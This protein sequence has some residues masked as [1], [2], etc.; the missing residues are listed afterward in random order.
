MAATKCGRTGGVSSGGRRATASI[1]R[2]PRERRGRGGGEKGIHTPGT[3]PDERLHRSRLRGGDGPDAGAGQT[4]GHAATIP[5]PSAAAFGE[6]TV[7]GDP[8]SRMSIFAAR[9]SELAPIAGDRIDDRS[10][11]APCPESRLSRAPVR[12]APPAEGHPR[13]LR[14]QVDLAAARD[15]T[16]RRPF[17][18]NL[19]VSRAPDRNG[20]GRPAR[21]HAKRPRDRQQG[22]PL[23]ACGAFGARRER[24]RCRRRHILDRPAPRG[25]PCEAQLRDAEQAQVMAGI[26][27]ARSGGAGRSP[28]SLRPGR[29]PTARNPRGSATAWQRGPNPRPVFGIRLVGAPRKRDRNKPEPAFDEGDA[30]EEVGPDVVHF[31]PHRDPGRGEA[32]DKGRSGGGERRRGSSRGLLGARCRFPAGWARPGSGRHEP[33]RPRA[34]V[35]RG[36][37]LPRR[38]PPGL[39]RVP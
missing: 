30:P 36:G 4:S 33:R 29:R 32:E 20:K 25:R 15:Q 2:L 18:R 5:A 3:E 23:F 19:T 10:A 6:S 16:A 28:S 9:F 38:L 1:R 21:L 34:T 14:G 35:S 11:P 24:A 39:R 22:R 37:A 12:S 27:G 26:L 17:S 31:D 13:H 8:S 7:I